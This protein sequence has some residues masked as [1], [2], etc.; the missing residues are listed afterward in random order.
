MSYRYRSIG[1]AFL[2][3]VRT[4]DQ[5]VPAFTL[6]LKSSGAAGFGAVRVSGRRPCCAGPG[7]Q[8]KHSEEM[9]V[10]A[11]A[12]SL[13]A[14][15]VM[16]RNTAQMQKF[17][18][19]AQR[20]G[21]AVPLFAGTAELNPVF[22]SIASQTSYSVSIGPLLNPWC[23]SRWSRR[24]ER[25][26]LFTNAALMRVRVATVSKSGVQNLSTHGLSSISHVQAL[27]GCRRTWR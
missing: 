18:D 5:P 15:I 17:L 3:I 2:G 4:G 11:D 10:V 1:H 20:R 22:C 25:G 27:R 12:L 19:W 7:H 21:D 13:L 14:N 23:S 24:T 16:F 26:T 6:E 8:A 9:Q